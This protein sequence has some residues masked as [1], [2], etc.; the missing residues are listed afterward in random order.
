[1]D[2]TCGPTQKSTKVPGQLAH[3]RFD[4]LEIFGHERLFDHEVVEEPL[5][6]RRTDSTLRRRIEIRDGGREQVRRRVTQE[7]QRVG[8]GRHDQPKRGVRLERIRQ[9]DH[10]PIDDGRERLPHD[11]R[12]QR[13]DGEVPH[14]RAT[15]HIFPRTVWKRQGDQGRKTDKFEVRS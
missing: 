13:R 14:R 5:V 9:I 3:L 15:R 8:V 7:G 11:A 12:R 1:V 10:A 2:G 4:T 6:G